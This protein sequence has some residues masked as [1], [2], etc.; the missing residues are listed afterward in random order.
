MILILLIL[1]L[2]I[3][4]IIIDI[5]DID[6]DIIDIDID[7]DNNNNYWY[8]WSSSSTTLVRVTCSLNRRPLRGETSATPQNE[9]VISWLRETSI[10]EYC[11]T[12]G[13]TKPVASRPRTSSVRTSSVRARIME[14]LARAPPQCRSRPTAITWQRKIHRV[15]IREY[16]GVPDPLPPLLPPWHTQ[17]PPDIDINIIDIDIDN[18]NNNYWYY[19]YW[20]EYYWYCWW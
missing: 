12:H 7:N 1:I 9:T 18:N 5:I 14:G 4:I 17:L 15:L 10:N 11:Q 8:Y 2:L 20:Y 6:V 16:A 19:W 13:A 3:I